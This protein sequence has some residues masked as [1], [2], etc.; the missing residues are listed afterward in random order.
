MISRSR[1]AR[2]TAN[3]AD[4]LRLNPLAGPLDR[5]LDVLRIAIDAAD[6]DQVLEPAR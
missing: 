1:P 5:H 3:A 4:R 2:S 6:D